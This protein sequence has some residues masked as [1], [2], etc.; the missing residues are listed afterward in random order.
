LLVHQKIEKGSPLIHLWGVSGLDFAHKLS[1]SIA[2]RY[3][4]VIFED[5]NVK[6]MQQFNGR[7][8]GDNIMGTLVSLTKYKVEE[9]C[10]L[11]NQIGRF[12]KST[13]ICISMSIST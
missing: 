6:A 12:V 2:K 3:D 5:L 13:G 8:V 9:R 11:F 7:M 1:N 4:I 10:G